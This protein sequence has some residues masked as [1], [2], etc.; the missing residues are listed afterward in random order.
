VRQ[1]HFVRSRTAHGLKRSQFPDL[2]SILIPTYDYEVL[3]LATEVH[4]QCVAAGIAFE[5]LVLDDA[6]TN[7]KSGNARINEL[8]NARFEVLAQNVGRSKIRNLLASKAKFDW[9]LFLDSDTFPTHENFISNYV[10]EIGKGQ[11]ALN[12]GIRYS[13][14]KPAR[15]R[16]L[17]WTYGR[18]REALRVSERQKNPYLSFLSLNFAIPKT[19]F[20]QVKFDETLPNLRHEDTVFSHRMKRLGIPVTHIENPV[21]HLGL[22]EFDIM[23][24]KEHEALFAL[25][26]LVSENK[27]DAD[28]VKMARYYRFLKK[29]HLDF[30]VR[31]FFRLTRKSLLSDISKPNP[32]LFW[33]D[34]YRL[35]YICSI[36]D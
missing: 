1:Q 28:Y 13:D 35:G 26:N 29:T 3:G 31:N 24:K 16:I 6:S 34:V 21:L 23:L 27:I 25:K 9:L 5:V 8:E 10:S 30:F 7:P 12:G 17:R 15:D 14:E 19:L 18:R 32:S 36:P 22:D 33:Y 20:D 4:R 11:K 2:L